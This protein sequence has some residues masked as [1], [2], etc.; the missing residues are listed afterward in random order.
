MLSNAGAKVNLDARYVLMGNTYSG[1]TNHY[2]VVAAT[3]GTRLCFQIS[4]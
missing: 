4:M 2:Y 1:L 3:A